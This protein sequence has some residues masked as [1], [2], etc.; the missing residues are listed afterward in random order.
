V[1]KSCIALAIGG[2]RFGLAYAAASGA[3]LIAAGVVTVLAS[4]YGA[5]A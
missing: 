4:W 3:A 5:M 2:R 1:A